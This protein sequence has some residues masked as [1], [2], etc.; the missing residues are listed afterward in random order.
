ME[1]ERKER[2]GSLD[3]MVGGQPIIHKVGIIKRTKRDSREEEKQVS[4][5]ISISTFYDELLSTTS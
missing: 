5:T 1:K 4:R 3:S 2:G